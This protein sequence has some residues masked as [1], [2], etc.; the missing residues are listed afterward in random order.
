MIV[1][2]HAKINLTLDI[3]GVLPNG[4]HTVEMVM[5]SVSLCDE[6]KL[7][8]SNNNQINLRCTK[9]YIP[10]NNRNVAYKA[11]EAFL[12]ATKVKH[13]GVYIK[14]YK[15]IPVSAGLAGGSS[16]A[17]AVLVGLNR[18]FGTGLTNEELCKL[19][20]H[21]GADIPFCI[22]GGTMLAQGIGEKLSPL[23]Q[24]PECYILLVKPPL[25]VS[26][27]AAYR[28]YN[29]TL[30]A[31]RPDTR[32]MTKALEAGDTFQ[33]SKNMRNVFEELVVLKHV[34]KIKRKLLERE[35]LGAQMSGS[36]PTVIGIFD[37]KS[38]ANNC[39]I[40]MRKLYKDVFLCEPVNYGVRIVENS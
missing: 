2:S 11:A 23:P 15:N 37:D 30:L 40:Y 26:T 38:R 22:M 27:E 5:Q 18:L 31:N 39:A 17:A 6:V 34:E 24:M 8:H 36:G 12:N 21:L 19:G 29:R 3:T 13:T 4:Y 1:K 16:N 10:I 33:I 20:V 32:A 25:N 35:A 9:P 14:L 28:K 7:D